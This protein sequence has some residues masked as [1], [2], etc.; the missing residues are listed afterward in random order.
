MKVKGGPYTTIDR[1]VARRIRD[2]NKRYPNL[3]HEGL[4]KVLEQQGIHVDEAEFKRFV[5]AH[6]L[7][8]G[9]AK[10][11]MHHVAR[12]IWWPFWQ[13]VIAIGDDIGGPDGGNK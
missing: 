12:R 13:R 7:D 2:A 5:L 6:D 1:S 11:T 10:P 3:G 4:T 9:T 8:P